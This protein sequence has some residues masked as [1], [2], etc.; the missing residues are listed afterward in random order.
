MNGF[1]K[2]ITYARSGEYMQSWKCSNLYPRRA[3]YGIYR[4]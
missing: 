4:G 2:D 1:L 3:D